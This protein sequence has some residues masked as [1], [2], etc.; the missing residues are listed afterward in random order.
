MWH[1]FEIVRIFNHG[2]QMLYECI[3]QLL[4][5]SFVLIPSSAYRQPF[6]GVKF[7]NFNLTEL[8]PI[9]ERHCTGN[10][11]VFAVGICIQY[12]LSILPI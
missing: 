7:H 6:H 2:V 11:R 3:E 10:C 9:T 1:G 12:W 8:I 5:I 4:G